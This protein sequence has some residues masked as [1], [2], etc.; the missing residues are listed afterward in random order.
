MGKIVELTYFKITFRYSK[1]T[2]DG[3]QHHKAGTVRTATWTSLEHFA[4]YT[5]L[6]SIKHEDVIKIKTV[7]KNVEEGSWDW[8]VYHA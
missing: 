7:R 1:D 3:Y 2:F 8:K 4:Q 6:N 5:R